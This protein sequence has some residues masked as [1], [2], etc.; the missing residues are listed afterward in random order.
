MVLLYGEIFRLGGLKP[1]II[2]QGNKLFEMS[3][4]KKGQITKTVFRDT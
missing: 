3:V 4:E 1:S 2:R